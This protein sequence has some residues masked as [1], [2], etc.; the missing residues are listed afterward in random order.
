M[1]HFPLWPSLGWGRA[2]LSPLWLGFE[3]DFLSPE[4]KRTKSGDC[5]SKLSADDLIAV[6]GSSFK[7]KEAGDLRKGG[8]GV[9]PFFSGWVGLVF[10]LAD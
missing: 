7:I 1:T 2:C 8:L 6:Q 4:M 3:A 9:I 5:P 10:R